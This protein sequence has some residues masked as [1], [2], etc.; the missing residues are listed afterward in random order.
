M[1]YILKLSI[2]K[3]K[4]LIRLL[5]LFWIFAL[6]LLA[7]CFGFYW[8]ILKPLKLEIASFKQ[9]ISNVHAQPKNTI[10]SIPKNLDSKQQLTAFY[11]FFPTQ[12]NLLDQ[13]G[14]I[15]A[16]AESQNLMLEQGEYNIVDEI[17]AKLI[18]YSIELPVKGDYL[19]I[20]KF[21]KKSL[22]DVPN[23]ALESVYFTRQKIDDPH[24]SSKIHFI[25]Y[26]GER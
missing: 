22:L 11:H 15:Y 12:E 18:R 13:L 26:V 9:N 8:I 7:F 6:V 20:R 17:D 19:Q 3:I 5:G 23:L 14:K 4:N 16:A 21:I 25:L 1:R 24:V 10:K 2:W